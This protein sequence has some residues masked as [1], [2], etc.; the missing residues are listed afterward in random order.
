MQKNY[1]ENKEKWKTWGLNPAPN[2]LAILPNQLSYSVLLC[3]HR[4]AYFYYTYSIE[5]LYTSICSKYLGIQNT[6][7]LK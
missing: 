3:H 7:E 1:F 4:I 6:L 5:H 2:V